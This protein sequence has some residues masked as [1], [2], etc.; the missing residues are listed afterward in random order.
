MKG[1]YKVYSQFYNNSA[2]E[3]LPGMKMIEAYDL[4]FLS[5]GSDKV[6]VLTLQ[7]E[8]DSTGTK[9]YHAVCYYSRRGAYPTRNHLGKFSDLATAH[10]LMIKQLKAKRSKGYVDK[11]HYIDEDAKATASGALGKKVL[12]FLR[13]S[14]PTGAVVKSPSGGI[15]NILALDE[16]GALH[17]NQHGGDIK[18]IPFGKYG[19]LEVVK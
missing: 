1:K 10:K 15:A 13:E 19:M 8:I 12:D 3:Y 7:E 18:V 6:Y 5:S 2:V 9:S 11:G 14:Y 4:H 16:N 17:V